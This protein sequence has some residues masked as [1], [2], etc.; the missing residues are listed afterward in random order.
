MYWVETDSKSM[1]SGISV[2]SHPEHTGT[3]NSIRT[4]P[5]FGPLSYGNWNRP[6]GPQ[7]LSIGFLSV[8]YIFYS[9]S[10]LRSKAGHLVL[11]TMRK[12]HCFH[13]RVYD[14]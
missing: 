4:M 7:L 11:E 5:T 14:N 3:T 9:R 2:S 12:S 8:S 13:L 6:W 10:T 1:N